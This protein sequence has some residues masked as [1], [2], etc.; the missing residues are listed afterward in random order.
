VAVAGCRQGGPFQTVS[1]SQSLLVAAAAQPRA[2][3]AASDLSCNF[4]LASDRYYVEDH[5]NHLVRTFTGNLTKM[6]SQMP[7]TFS[8]LGSSEPGAA[9]GS[10][11]AAAGGSNGA[12]PSTRSGE[13]SATRLMQVG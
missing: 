1:N 9:H 12:G 7:G 6:L 2:V 5:S 3:E 11:A 8:K 10:S 4:A 13:W